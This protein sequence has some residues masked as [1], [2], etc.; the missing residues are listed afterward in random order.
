VLS[1]WRAGRPSKD[2]GFAWLRDQASRAKTV[3][4]R[5][6]EF[7]EKLGDNAPDMDAANLHPWAWEN[8][9]SFWN[10]GHYHQAVMQAA[11]RI[12]AE[13]QA[14]LGRMDVSETALLNEAFSLSDPKP[15]AA[16]LRLMKDDSSK[17]YENLH[18]GHEHLPRVS[19]PRS[20][21]RGCMHQA[22]VARNSS[23]WSNSLRSASLP[24]GLTGLRS[25]GS[26]ARFG[27]PCH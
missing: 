20:V 26:D 18:R 27:Y 19:M 11:I 7:A 24:A 12:N 9:S 6:E 25:W 4:Q 2:E 23:H 10:T 17:T 3:L 1:G 5:S 16:R 21:I 22:T 14:K 13:T 15:G 8:G